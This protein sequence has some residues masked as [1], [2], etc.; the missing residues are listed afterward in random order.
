MRHAAR[1]ARDA[2]GAAVD[3]AAQALAAALRDSAGVNWYRRLLWQL[4][5]CYDAMGE[6]YSY[7]VHLVAQRAA[8]DAQENFARRAGALFVSRLKAAPWWSEV[9]NG[10]PVR[11]GVRPVEA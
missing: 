5:R 1:D 11:V 2:R 7:Q 9:M 4:L 3:M 10:P 8:V 6:D